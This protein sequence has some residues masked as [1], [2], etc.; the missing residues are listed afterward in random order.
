MDEAVVHLEFASEQVLASTIRFYT[1]LSASLN[2]ADKVA[3]IRNGAVPEVSPFSV[4]VADPQKGT[5]TLIATYK[6][7]YTSRV[8]QTKST[9]T[10]S[11]VPLTPVRDFDIIKHIEVLRTR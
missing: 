9:P 5:T 8:L 10:A 6:A 3:F 11:G 7:L 2:S 1:F 4:L